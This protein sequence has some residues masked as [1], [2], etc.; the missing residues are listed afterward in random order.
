MLPILHHDKPSDKKKAL[1]RY[2]PFLEAWRRGPS[3]FVVRLAA[4]HRRWK[5]VAADHLCRHL[6]SSSFI[7]AWT[8]RVLESTLFALELLE[9]L[10]HTNTAS[11]SL[12]FVAI[13]FKGVV[14]GFCPFSHIKVSGGPLQSKWGA[15][16]HVE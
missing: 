4:F 5:A 15:L 11:Y 2:R 8:R 14:G 9:L 6:L 13:C 1:A 16:G 12:M 10:Y 3:P 7:S